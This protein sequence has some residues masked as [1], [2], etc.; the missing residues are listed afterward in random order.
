MENKEKYIDLLIELKE[1]AVSV[2]AIWDGT[3][4]DKKEENAHI[5][6]EIIEH[7]DQIINLLETLN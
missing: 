7:A 4:N 1:N 3:N 5:A 2:E 6:N